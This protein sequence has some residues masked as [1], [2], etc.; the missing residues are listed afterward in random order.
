MTHPETPEDRPGD[1]G[2][3]T[4]MTGTRYPVDASADRRAR[5]VWVTLIGGPVIWFTHFMIVYL[6]AEAA[7]TG[8]GPGMDLFT[9][10]VVEIVIG[11]ATVVA[12]LGCL[13]LIR[14]GRSGGVGSRKAN[15]SRGEGD[16]SLSTIHSGLLLSGLSLIAILF[17]T[18]PVLVL[19]P[20]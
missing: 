8:D 14:R 15:S 4:G 12:A 6:I 9:T 18:F 17:V 5:G 16:E 13:L 2:G 11:A 3:W 20:C 7:C 19:P 1:A 10:P